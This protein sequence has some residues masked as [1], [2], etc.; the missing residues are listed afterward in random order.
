MEF[1]GKKFVVVGAGISGI[2]AVRLLVNRDAIVTLYDG[3]LDEDTIREKLVSDLNMVKISTGEF[4]ESLIEENDCM[5]ISPGVP[6][7][8]D[9]VVAFKNAGKTVIGEVELAYQCAKG[10]LAAITGTNGKTT[11]TA[12]VGEIFAAY[13][14]SSFV[15]GNI[16]NAYTTEADNMTDESVTVAEISSFQMES[17]VEFH[18]VVSC[19]LNVTPDHLDRHKTMENYTACKMMVTKNQTEDEVCV[20]N[21]EDDILNKEAKKLNCKKVYFSS[22]TV[23]SDGYYLDGK[24]IYKAEGGNKTYLL[25]MKDMI[26]VGVHN[27]ENAMAAIAIA[28]AMG[29]PMD[30]II[31]TVKNFKAVPHRIEYVDEIDG[32]VY[33]ND[34]KG[35]NPDATI[36]AV[37]AMDKPIVLIAGGYDKHVSFADMAKVLNGRVKTLVLLGET[38]DEIANEARNAGV[39]NI[40]MVDSLEEA[41]NVSKD[42]AE[43]G[44]VVL[45]SPA[46]A[47]WDMF[48]SYTQRG[49]LFKEYVNKLKR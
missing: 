1:K 19:V 36:K 18:P 28:D 42:N 41:V 25:S 34:S 14:K 40:I 15:V 17:A 43:R 8:K 9:F 20:L 27:A 22:K 16:G 46:C 2:G 49:D 48:K 10:K 4:D 24:D 47:S 44:D 26:I 3:K 6:I 32:V 30:V 33:Y 7:D 5:V 45:L 23:L 29:V 21:Y 35:T 12:L 31:E 37:E 38:R 11:T 39:T 13:F